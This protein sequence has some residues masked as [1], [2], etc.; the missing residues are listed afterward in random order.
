MNEGHRVYKLMEMWFKEAAVS[1][2]AQVIM[3]DFLSRYHAT[4]VKS[5]CSHELA[6]EELFSTYLELIRGLNFNPIAFE[7]YHAMIIK[8]VNYYQFGIDFASPLVNAN[9]SEYVGEENL[10]KIAQQLKAKENVIFLANHQT[11]IDPQ[12]L[13]ILLEKKHPDL[14]RDIIYVAGDRVIS[15]CLAIPMSLGRNLLCIYSKK[16]I[17]NPPERKE[18]KRAS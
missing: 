8:P 15:D 16:H 17:N 5:G 13:N 4:V 10:I 18:E 9:V 11:E 2:K 14:G 1:P 6:V 7:S 3:K 12:L